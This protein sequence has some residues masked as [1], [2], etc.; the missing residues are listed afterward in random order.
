MPW[1]VRLWRMGPLSLFRDNLGRLYVRWAQGVLRPLG[2]EARK[3]R[4]ISIR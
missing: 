4:A 2:G 1:V 3:K